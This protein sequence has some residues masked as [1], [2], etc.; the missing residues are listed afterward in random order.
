MYWLAIVAALYFGRGFIG[1]KLAPYVSGVSPQTLVVCG[2]S[3]SLA[4]GLLFVLPVE[5]LGLAPAKRFMFFMCLANSGMAS[6]V[7]VT[8]VYGWPP[9]PS[10]MSFSALRSG[11]AFTQLAPYIQRVMMGP[12]FQSLF[13]SLIFIA[14]PPS[15]L[16]LP[17]LLRRSLWCLCIHCTSTNSENR[18]WLRFQPTW[19]KLRAPTVEAE[20][21]Q[22][23]ALAEILLG[24]WFVVNLFLPT[25][26]IITLVLY[27]NY[28][29]I[30]Y[31]FEKTDKPF[32]SKAWQ[33][34][35]AKVEPLL[36]MLP[37]LRTPLEW[38]KSW[39]QPKFGR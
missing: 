26:Q 38:L 5:L 24:F 12:D 21:L 36:C 34:L 39:F 1:K 19:K 13:Y 31:Q 23:N 22:Y 6:A 8:R 2:H 3:V 17:V 29:K 27:W 25:R 15:L 14:A 30:R 28:L 37:F 11:A 18:L 10:D 9:V 32:H 33:R 7:S 4:C 16:V 20:V 35:G